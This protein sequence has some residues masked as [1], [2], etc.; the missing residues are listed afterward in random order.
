M[1]RTKGALK[2]MSGPQEED[3]EEMAAH[4]GE[5]EVAGVADPFAEVPGVAQNGIAVLKLVGIEL[6]P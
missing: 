2:Q 3:L 1:R 6:P 5:L 4:W